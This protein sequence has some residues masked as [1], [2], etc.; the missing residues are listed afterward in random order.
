MRLKIILFGLACYAIYSGFVDIRESLAN[1]EA[2][3]YTV[4]SYITERPTGEWVTL[5]EGNLDIPDAAYETSSE[6]DDDV[7]KLYVP[8]YSIDEFD[9]ET[10]NILFVT[11]DAELIALLQQIN[12]MGEDEFMEF[13]FENIE[14]VFPEDDLTGMIRTQQSMESD[15]VSDLQGLYPSLA[16]DFV[17]LED[18]AMPGGILWGLT[19]I[20]G[21][22]VLLAL[23]FFWIFGRKRKPDSDN[24]PPPSNDANSGDGQLTAEQREALM[25]A[26]RERTAEQSRNSA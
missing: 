17:L 21:G 8:V 1:P 11:D 22:L 23:L 18:G 3:Q 2:L 9:Y 4:T 25:Q 10:I 7:S 13:A 5:T 26:L 16:P 14:R 24:T 12:A 15:D 6:D 20:A 19:L